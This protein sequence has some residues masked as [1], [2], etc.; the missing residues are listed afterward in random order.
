MST[1]YI[2]GAGASHGDSLIIADQEVQAPRPP[3]ASGFFDN[4]LLNAL[5]YA[6]AEQDLH[7]VIAY[8][9][10]TRLWTDK[11]G[12]GAWTGLN[13]EELFTSI[14]VERDFH[15]Q[16]SD[17]GAR[18][19]LLRNA[20]IRY[21]RRVLGS[22]TR[23]ARGKWHELLASRLGLDDSVVTFNWDLLFD[24]HFVG[25]W[26]VYGQY[27]HFLQRVPVTLPDSD[28]SQVIQGHGLLLKLHGSL[29]W[30]R[31]GNRKCEAS[32]KINFIAN[33]QQCLGWASGS[34][35]VTCWQCGSIMSQVIVP[36]LLRKPITDD[37]VI[38][39]AWGL[40]RERLAAASKVVVVGFSAAP[41][42]FYAAWLLNSTVGARDGVEVIVINPANAEGH[43]DHQGFRSRMAGIFPRG[44]NHRLLEFSEIERALA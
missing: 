38:R 14:E 6:L 35:E 25:K 33:V 7:E 9:R 12:E 23:G 43:K 22:C 20:L 27:N 31:C 13:L 16:E 32:E 5:G 30:F 11:F 29:N 18:L 1:V 26:R 4:A 40:A 39:S 36:P 17:D 37:P 15:S 19:L 3:L 24:Q 21:I 8:V 42:D 41:T 10:K 2:I 34:E 44:Y 28:L